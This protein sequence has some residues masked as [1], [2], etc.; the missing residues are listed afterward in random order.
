MMLLARSASSAC[1]LDSRCVAG[2][3]AV[4]VVTT[5][6]TASRGCLLLQVG[7]PEKQ[8]SPARDRDCARP[9]VLLRAARPALWALGSIVRPRCL[10]CWSL[11]AVQPRCGLKDGYKHPGARPIERPAGHGAHNLQILARQGRGRRRS[12]VKLGRGQQ[13]LLAPLK[14]VVML[15][16]HM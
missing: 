8:G 5:H 13:A 9:L 6:C 3:R 4:P 12:W 11:E 15:D 7:R 2:S 10:C 1:R 16:P 14:P